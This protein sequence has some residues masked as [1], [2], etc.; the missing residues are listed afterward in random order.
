M[1]YAMNHPGVKRQEAGV[2]KAQGIV[3]EELKR[4]GWPEVELRRRPKGHPGKVV[5]ARRLRQEATMRLKG[6]A[7]RL[8][9][10]SWA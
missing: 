8:Q 9:M 6:M 4:L 5:V 7:E 3:R 1:H 10:G 2:Q